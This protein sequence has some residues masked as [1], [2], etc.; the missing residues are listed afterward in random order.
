[1]DLHDRTGLAAFAVQ[2]KL[3]QP[4]ILVR[5]PSISALA[6]TWEKSQVGV[7]RIDSM[8]RIR[9]VARDLVDQFLNAYL[10]VNPNR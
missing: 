1:M 10:S 5:D 6:T 3:V 4:V 8:P 9:E 2:C 7:V